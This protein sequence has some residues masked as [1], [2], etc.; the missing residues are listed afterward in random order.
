MEQ[1]NQK[2]SKSAVQEADC[3]ALE[4]EELEEVVER[5]MGNL[6]SARESV[7]SASSRRKENV[8]AISLLAR[9]QSTDSPRT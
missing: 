9:G 7:T 6:S 8:I 5:L 2:K 4:N 1:F 3:L